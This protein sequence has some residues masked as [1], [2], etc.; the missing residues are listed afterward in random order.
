MPV[1]AAPYS[2]KCESIAFG[3]RT[4]RIHAQVDV[5]FGLDA[6]EEADRQRDRAGKKRFRQQWHPRILPSALF[7]RQG[8]LPTASARLAGYDGGGSEEHSPHS[9]HAKFPYAKE[10]QPMPFLASKP[11]KGGKLVLRPY[12]LA[13]EVTAKAE[14]LQR[15]LDGQFELQSSGQTVASQHIRSTSVLVF[16]SFLISIA[17][18]MITCSDV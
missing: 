5:E 3:P 1:S 6:H 15:V 17:W 12:G 18:P 7:G 4:L 16:F 11:L 9:P 2:K 14:L 8:W 10:D 13:E